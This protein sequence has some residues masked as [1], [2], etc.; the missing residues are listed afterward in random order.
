MPE[1]EPVSA[2]VARLVA[3]ASPL[4]WQTG[5]HPAY[6]WNEDNAHL[7]AFW[8]NDAP[9]DPKMRVTPRQSKANALLVVLATAAL[10]E[11]VAAL[12][13]IAEEPVPERYRG[14]NIRGRLLVYYELIAAKAL[15]SVRAALGG[16]G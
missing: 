15:A 4:P 16:G 14:Q 6:I 8:P 1:Q 9:I 12:E 13:G 2:L 3:E 10:P 11:L 7:A 5:K